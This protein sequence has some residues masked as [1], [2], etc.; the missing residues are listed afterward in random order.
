MNQNHMLIEE[1]NFAKFMLAVNK[2]HSDKASG[3]DGLNPDFFQHF[4]EM[5]GL[6]VFKCCK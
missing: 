3:P 2:M 5:L 1:V 4:W 6:D